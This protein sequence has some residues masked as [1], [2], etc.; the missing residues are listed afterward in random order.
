M[1]INKFTKSDNVA[2]FYSVGTPSDFQTANFF[3][4]LTKVILL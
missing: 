2:D 4:I 1:D 3:L